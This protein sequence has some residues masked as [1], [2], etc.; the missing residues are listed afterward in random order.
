M[1]L[2]NIITRRGAVTLFFRVRRCVHSKRNAAGVFR[3]ISLLMLLVTIDGAERRT[4][5][6]NETVCLYFVTTGDCQQRISAD[7]TN[8]YYLNDVLF[9]IKVI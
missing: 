7:R 5:I 8:Y 4:Y 9:G 1:S 6:N 3:K 2:V